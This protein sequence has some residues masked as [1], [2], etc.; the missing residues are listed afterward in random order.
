MVNKALFLGGGTW[1][2]GWLTSHNKFPRFGKLPKSGGYHPCSEDGLP[3]RIRGDR[4]GPPFISHG[5]R[6]FGRGTTPVR[7]LTIT[8]VANYFLTGMILQV[9]TKRPP[10]R[11]K[12]LTV[13]VLSFGPLI[14]LKC[15]CLSE[16]SGA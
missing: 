11:G 13:V 8:I 3:F 16:N 9:A 7:G 5:F 10:M 15:F 6:P 1:G 2:G 4:M 14:T 12:R